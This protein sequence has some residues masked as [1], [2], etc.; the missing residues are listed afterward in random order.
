M[1]SIFTRSFP[2]IK[3]SVP[4]QNLFLPSA[5]LPLSPQGI[6]LPPP[7]SAQNFQSKKEERA[8]ARAS[9][10][11]GNFPTQPKV[12]ES[13]IFED[14]PCISE[15][16]IEWGPRFIA[17]LSLSELHATFPSLPLSLSHLLPRWETE[18]EVI[19]DDDNNLE[20]SSASSCAASKK[21]RGSERAGR[22]LIHPPAPARHP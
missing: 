5:V 12:R 21:D 18:L 1:H 20:K 15:K 16:R 11:F 19:D 4:P 7:S 2:E 9:G 8:S 3:T 14:V 6:T 13:N 22:R 17:S 10:L